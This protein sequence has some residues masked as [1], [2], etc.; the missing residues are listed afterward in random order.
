[1]QRDKF[2]LK[3]SHKLVPIQGELI[4]NFKTNLYLPHETFKIEMQTSWQ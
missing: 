1:M 2:K 4:T 3:T